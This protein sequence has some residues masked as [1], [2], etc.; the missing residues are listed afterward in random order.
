MN[1]EELENV[2]SKR[3]K[4]LYIIINVLQMAAAFL[5]LMSAMLVRDNKTLYVIGIIVRMNLGLW[6]VINGVWN[7]FTRFYSFKRFKK[8]PR[9]GWLLLILIGIMCI[10]TAF[11]GYGF[12]NVEI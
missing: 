5:L 2:D 9:W 3:Y 8:I 10:V 6:C 1:K 12:N 4:K 7:Y 11:M